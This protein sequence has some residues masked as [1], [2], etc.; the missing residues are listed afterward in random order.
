MKGR[1]NET[2]RVS[3]LMGR[4]DD[5]GTTSSSDSLCSE[6]NAAST[7]TADEE[8]KEVGLERS[9]D[10]SAGVAGPLGED[11]HVPY[12]EPRLVFRSSL[13]APT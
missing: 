10:P 1:S 11:P 5:A 2:L 12:D 8:K 4:P 6:V 13:V 3:D 7:S 9:G